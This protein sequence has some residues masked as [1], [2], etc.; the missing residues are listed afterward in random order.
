MAS[1]FFVI[2]ALGIMLSGSAFADERQMSRPVQDNAQLAANTPAFDACVTAQNC[3]GVYQGCIG[4][5]IARS[6]IDDQE[7]RDSC[8]AECSPSLDRCLDKARRDCAN[9]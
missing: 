2:A 6:S 9:R 3:A 4:R 5:C 7:H 1:Y 8:S